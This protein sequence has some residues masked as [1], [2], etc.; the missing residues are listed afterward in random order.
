[1]ISFLFWNLA[2]RPILENVARIVEMRDIDVVMLAECAIDPFE[3]VA[4][5]NGI[6]SA[7]YAFPRSEGD[8]LRIF[9][10]FPEISLIEAFNDPLGR[11]TI[12][13]LDS[14]GSPEILLAVVH[15]PSRVNRSRDDQTL[16]ATVLATDIVEQEA[17]AGHRRTIVVGDLNMN[18]FDPGVAGAQALH[19]M[20]TRDLALREERV[21]NGRPYRFFSNPMWGC[22]GDRTEGPPGTHFYHAS[23]P[24]DP[25]WNTY[26]QVLLRPSLMGR[27]ERLMILDTDGYDSLVG[28]RGRPTVSDHFP[29]FF[30]LDLR[31][32]AHPHVGDDPQPLVG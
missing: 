11:V 3:V 30:R 13:S 9:T 31:D 6:G 16:E 12:R 29:L 21:V 18:R 28:D 27:L 4:A 8:K 7:R 32:G 26:D 25:F 14:E 17:R 19:A 22:F 24:S 1:M 23:G 20:M 2:K 5:L 10:R 15:F